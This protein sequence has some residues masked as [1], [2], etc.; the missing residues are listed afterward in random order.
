M[1]LQRETVAQ[2]LHL[3][4]FAEENTQTPISL[5]ALLTTKPGF[6]SILSIALKP[7]CALVWV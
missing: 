7:K 4:I 5:L 2:N 3:K 6:E 1:S